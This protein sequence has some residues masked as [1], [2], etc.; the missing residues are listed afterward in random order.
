M[1]CCNLGILFWRSTSGN[2]ATYEVWVDGVYK[3]DL[4]AEFLD[5]WG[6]YAY[7][8]EIFVSNEETEHTVMLKKKAGSAGDDFVL[9]RLMLSH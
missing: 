7:S 9:L 8:Q 2:Y 6:A 1:A 3:E 4:H 5:G